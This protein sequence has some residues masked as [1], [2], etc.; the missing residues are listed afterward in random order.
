ME[1]EWGHLVGSG[2]VL[3]LG[4]R[5]MPLLVAADKEDEM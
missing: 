5:E 4:C 2:L 3:M 1:I